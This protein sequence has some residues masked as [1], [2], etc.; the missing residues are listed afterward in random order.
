MALAAAL[1]SEIVTNLTSPDTVLPGGCWRG[2]AGVM[3]VAGVR[4]ES[5]GPPV[6]GR[7][8]GTPGPGAK[9]W[10]KMRR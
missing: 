1:N 6:T 3:V 2:S 7:Q 8:L 5:S 10:R 9:F 4:K